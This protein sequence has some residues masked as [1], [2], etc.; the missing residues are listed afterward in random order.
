MAE[1]L[2]ADQLPPCDLSWWSMVDAFAARVHGHGTSTSRSGLCIHVYQH[3]FLFSS[4]GFIPNDSTDKIS[5]QLRTMYLLTCTF[6]SWRN[7]VAWDKAAHEKN[8]RVSQQCGFLF[9]S[10]MTLFDF[11]FFAEGGEKGLFQNH[12]CFSGF[13]TS[14]RGFLSMPHQQSILS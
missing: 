7:N 8:G 2:S 4:G 14:P 5:T 1:V 3:C 13:L 12:L 6:T 10:R 9:T 11:I